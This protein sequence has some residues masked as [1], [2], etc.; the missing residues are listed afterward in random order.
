MAS[1]L[2]KWLCRTNE[3]T[4]TCSNIYLCLNQS[5]IAF[6]DWTLIA[7]VMRCALLWEWQRSQDRPIPL[8]FETFHHR[9]LH[10]NSAVS[11]M[12]TLCCHS[13][14]L[15]QGARLLLK[16]RPQL[17]RALPVGVH[18][19]SSLTS[20]RPKR[21]L[22]PPVCVWE[23]PDVDDS[24][25]LTL[26]QRGTAS[27]TGTG[28]WIIGIKGSIPVLE[29]Y[30]TIFRNDIKSCTNKSINSFCLRMIQK[31]GWKW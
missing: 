23:G 8:F 9:H 22:R 7:Y 25:D 24:E 6:P 28:A 3:S 30:P 16:A 21:R 5:C 4:E 11:Q 1:E 18:Y 29:R 2:Y 27:Q 13:L 20:L 10:S 31:N 15:S 17:E 14:V 26:E 19:R 12:G